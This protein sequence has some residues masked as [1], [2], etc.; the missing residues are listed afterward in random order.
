MNQRMFSFY[1]IIM[2]IMMKNALQE[3]GKITLKILFL[4]K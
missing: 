4:T 1:K 3:Y 2:K